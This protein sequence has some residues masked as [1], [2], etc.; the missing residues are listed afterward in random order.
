MAY[1]DIL[2]HLERKENNTH[3]VERHF[4]KILRHQNTLKGHK[5]CINSDYNVDILWE[6]EAITTELV[7]NL[8]NEFKVDL[9][10]YAKQNN[11]LEDDC[12]KQFKHIADREKHIIHLANQEQ[13]RSFRLQ[14]NI[15][16]VCSAE[17]LPEGLRTG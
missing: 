14:S 4:Q 7:E 11:L 1:N 5:Y 9:A 16:M 15:S 6:T 3:T 10:L 8:A 13:L 2:D 12:W 17:R